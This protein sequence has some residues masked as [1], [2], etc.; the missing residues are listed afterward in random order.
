M[1]WRRH[2]T[3]DGRKIIRSGRTRKQVK[4]IAKRLGIEYKE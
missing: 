2:H 4:N 1:K 3:N